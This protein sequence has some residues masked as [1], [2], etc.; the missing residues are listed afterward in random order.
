MSNL[1]TMREKEME[2]LVWEQ[3]SESLV[4][5]IKKMRFDELKEEILE[6]SRVRENA[7]KADRL[8]KEFTDMAV[9]RRNPKRALIWIR[10]RANEL[11]KSENPEDLRETIRTNYF[12]WGFYVAWL[13]SI[14]AKN[15]ASE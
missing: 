9:E 6:L 4:K 1:K 2:E 5:T 11:G 13:V 12:R 8:I 3:V 15:Y 14:L 7:N 10:D